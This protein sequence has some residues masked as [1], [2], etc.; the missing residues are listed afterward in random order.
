MVDQSVVGQRK[1]MCQQW[2]VDGERYHE[3]VYRRTNNTHNSC[4]KTTYCYWFALD[5]SL[6]SA[7][8]HTF[9]LLIHVYIHSCLPASLIM[10]PGLHC[11]FHSPLPTMHACWPW[12][13]SQLGVPFNVLNWL[14]HSTLTELFTMRLCMNQQWHLETQWIHA[15]LKQLQPLLHSDTA[16]L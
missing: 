5:V 11:Y 1:W 16:C 8:Q 15:G 13:E 12:L 2:K 9:W 6:S 7:S 3:H 4:R 14:P 10:Y